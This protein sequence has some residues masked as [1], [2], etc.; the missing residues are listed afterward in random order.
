VRAHRASDGALLWETGQEKEPG[1]AGHFRYYETFLSWRGAIL[2]PHGPGLAAYDRRTGERRWF[3]TPP[4]GLLG[5]TA[6]ADR[7]YLTSHRGLFALK[8]GP[9]SYSR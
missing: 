2:I 8:E 4:G 1:A 7:L 3:Y 6:D 9:K 5:L